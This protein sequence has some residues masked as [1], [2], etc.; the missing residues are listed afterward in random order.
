MYLA[1]LDW[2][3]P[4]LKQLTVDARRAP[5]RIFDAHLPDQCAKLRLD[6]RPPFVTSSASSCESRP[7]PTNE[8]LGTDDGNQ[9]YCFGRDVFAAIPEILRRLLQLRQN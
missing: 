8:R 1:T 2:A 6:L 3:K 5:K 7:D 4:E 9:R